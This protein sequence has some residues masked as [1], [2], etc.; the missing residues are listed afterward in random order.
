MSA[1]TA[2]PKKERGTGGTSSATNTARRPPSAAAN[3]NS[4]N[5]TPS[6]SPTRMAGQGSTAAT[7]N[8][9]RSVR[10]GAG[11]PLLARA[12]VRKA[13]TS[14]LI[15]DEDSKAEMQARLE[16]LREKLQ[17]TELAYEDSQKHAEV[18]QIRLD[19]ALHEQG[20]LEDSVQEHAERV[21]ELEHERK[22][23]LRA[24]REMEQ[25]YE[26]ERVQ[27]MEEREESQAREAEMQAVVQRLKEREMHSRQHAGVMD[28]DRRP[29]MSRAS[30]FRSNNAFPNPDT[31]FAP[32]SSLQRSDSRSSSRL[33]MQKDRVIE[34]LRLELAEAQI[35]LVELENQG[36]GHLQQLEK[37]MYDT[38]MQ[39]ARLMEENES[40]QLLLSEKTLNGDFAHSDL[41]RAPVLQ[42]S[43]PP[44]RA[45]TNHGTTL[46]DELDGKDDT[47]DMDNTSMF[48][49]V[50]RRLQGEVNSLKDQ[51]KALT[52]YINNIISRLLQHEHIAQQILDKTPDLM[53]G[54]G[55][56]TA[57]MK[58]AGQP[59]ATSD[60]DLP[61]PPPPKD[62]KVSAEDPNAQ[63][64]GLLQ[65]A[66]S[67]LRG[68]GAGAKP[69][70]PTSMMAHQ[71]SSTLSLQ[72]QSRE[73]SQSQ[74]RLAEQEQPTVH[75]NPSTAPSIPVPGRST[76]VR[77]NSG[78]RRA[79]S[80]WAAGVV[81]SMYRG[82]TPSLQS[83]PTSPGLS[84]PGGRG[85]SFFGAVGSLGSRAPSSNSVPT[86]SS[87][88]PE[89]NKENQNQNQSQH[90]AAPYR[91]SNR[92]SMQSNPTDL[93]PPPNIDFEPD[94][95][96]QLSLGS[97]T[98]SPPRSTTSSGERENMRP[99][100]GSIMMGSKPRPLRL[101]QEA[102]DESE[103]ARKAANRG[104]W[105]GWMNKAGVGTATPPAGP[106][107]GG[108]PY[109]G[110][111]GQR[112]V[113]GG[114]G[115]GAPS[116]GEQGGQGQ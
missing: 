80:E 72:Q 31:Q 23:S 63:N 90:P 78:H 107:A 36:G 89:R 42:D 75:E 30:S 102:N 93:N 87:S 67:V 81:T 13:A 33:V 19:E 59:P 29:S 35:K 108:N 22:E 7:V 101:V 14:D 100:G 94:T 68:R 92:N 96:A 58:Y 114:P 109:G 91:N 47:T 43:R 54:P 64:M 37:E 3:T 85:G 41:L 99:P 98:T 76:S 82:P 79:N 86:V 46:A 25:I 5:P 83:G 105:F 51:N 104:S 9:V 52:L 106:A 50:D 97:G 18:L 24:R 61:P 48:T 6:R 20:I 28:D 45:P 2:T 39:N 21:E 70:R 110:S 17:Q 62:E 60:K 103:K 16:E 115:G 113:S 32:S 66:G 55:A 11:T 26:A 8:R 65:R 40:F 111:I 74:T 69:P 88:D 71:A 53:A 95:L 44:S 112:S 57:S 38:K 1:V 49:D 73:Q 27:S 84:S 56:A 77:G 34:G 15:A 10:N 116:G 4:N 12:S